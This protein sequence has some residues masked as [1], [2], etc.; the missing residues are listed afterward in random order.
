MLTRTLGTAGFEVST[1]ADGGSALAAIERNAPDI[2]VLDVTMPGVG[3]LA[4]CQRLRAKGLTIPVLLL[5]ARDAISERVAGLEAGADDYLVKPFAVEELIA[6]LYALQRRGRVPEELL[7]VRDVRLEVA[8]GRAER[9]G[10][11]L[12]LTRREADVL[13]VLMRN[14]R[15][16]ITREQILDLVWEGRAGTSNVADRYVAY[17]REKLGDPPLIETV[18]G[19]GFVFGGL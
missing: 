10:Q 5:T 17:L 2:V 9:A 3:G 16:L 6:R 1:A 15:R 12:R 7:V 19:S 11:P 13:E 14:P 4:V 8:T 18:R